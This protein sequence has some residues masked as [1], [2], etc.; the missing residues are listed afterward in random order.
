MKHTRIFLNV[1]EDCINS[2]GIK[3]LFACLDYEK[4]IQKYKIQIDGLEA[5]GMGKFNRMYRTFYFN[6]KSTIEFKETKEEIPREKL[7]PEFDAIVADD[8]GYS[9]SLIEKLLS[10]LRPLIPDF[11]PYMIIL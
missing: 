3:V 8:I 4:C 11:Q 1:V 2:P 5:A 6:N 7:A 9:G 10:K